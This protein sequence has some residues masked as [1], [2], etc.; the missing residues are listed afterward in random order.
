MQIEIKKRQKS[1]SFEKCEIAKLPNN[2]IIF[3]DDI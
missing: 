3:N 2:H 1:K